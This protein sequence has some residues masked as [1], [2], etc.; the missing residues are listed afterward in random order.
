MGE[1]EPALESLV[2]S[3]LS[4]YSGRKVF[5]TGHTGFKG[6]WLC[7]WLHQLGA[8]VTGYA[9][10]PPTEPNLFELCGIGDLVHSVVADV[11][12]GD[13]LKKRMVEAN[14]EIVIHMAAQPLVRDS[15]E[16]PVDTYAVNVM[17]TVNVLEAVRLC[18]SVKAV[19]IVTTDKCYENRE[20]AWGYRENEPLGGADPYS[21]SKACSEIVTAAYRRSFFEGGKFST[22]GAA[23]ASARAG[24]VIGGGDWARD[25]LVPD[26]VRALLRGEE[27]LIRNPHAIRP[28][29]HVLEPL[30]GYLMLAERLCK[31][32]ARFSEAW[33]FGPG[34]E[35][36]KPVEWLVKRIC[37]EWGEKA[38]YAI[39]VG[40][41]PHE[42]HFLKLDS[43]K[44]R[45]EF[46][47]LPRWNLETAVGK[48]IEWARCYR[49]G[50]DLKGLCREQIWEYCGG[51]LKI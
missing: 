17:G 1:R 39:D 32:G 48:T 40:D 9:L 15:Y 11:R 29:Q 25:R 34:E 4:F 35:D 30:S 3:A 24:N 5:V 38:R 6:S 46:G 28:W 37:E 18:G 22:H 44:V 43:T 21:S 41:H 33:N 13:S 27:I 45:M 19:V 2:K 36:A 8:K 23:I 31:E 20:W 51:V 49:D 14:P 12:D 10:D 50:G 16:M 47:W 26:C 7:L 42:A